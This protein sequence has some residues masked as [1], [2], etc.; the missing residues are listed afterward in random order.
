MKGPPGRAP[1][2][3]M[4]TDPGAIETDRPARG[5][6]HRAAAEEARPEAPSPDAGRLPPPAA[7]V[8]RILAAGLVL[9][10]ALVV[11]VVLL[12]LW[13]PGLARA[14]VA[15]IAAEV[16][17]GREGGVPVALQG[18][19]P[20]P[21]AWQLSVTQDLAA[22]ALTFPL[23][24]VLLRRYHGSRRWPMRTVRRIER[25]AMRH[26][27]AIRRWGPVGI[28][29]FMVVPFLVNGPLIAATAGHLAHM[30][31]RRLWSA[32]V[33]ASMVAAAAW[34]WFFDATLGAIEEVGGRR[35]TLWFTVAVLS[36]IVGLWVLEQV[37]QARREG[38]GS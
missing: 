4:P 1:Q 20:P 34:V 22:A 28:F 13:D 2:V 6:K 7:P 23:V 33:A 8:R 21:L 19:V 37:R 29:V 31:H 10:V 11:E 12:T 26:H 36:L 25:A 17:T 9:L 5:R 18:G 38:R 3:A 24:A 15:G 35:A 16:F 14:A 30:P 27:D 32:I